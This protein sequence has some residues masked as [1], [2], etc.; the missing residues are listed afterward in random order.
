MGKVIENVVAEALAAE[1]VRRGL[2]SDGQYR[3]RASQ[4]AIDVVAIMVDRAHAALEE[5]HIAGILL[6]D[7]KA[8]FPS[9]GTGRLIHAM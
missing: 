8:A 2:H 6:V 7:I 5:G 9:V 1:A 3:R 4:S